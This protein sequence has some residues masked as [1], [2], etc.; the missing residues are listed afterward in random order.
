M[1]KQC[2]C[3]MCLRELEAGYFTPTWTGEIHDGT[4][5]DLNPEDLDT[6]TITGYEPAD[7][8]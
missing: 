2:T 6:E 7:A 8:I 5:W 3:E 4:Y 1:G